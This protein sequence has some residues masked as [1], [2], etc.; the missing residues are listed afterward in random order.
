MGIHL[1]NKDIKF[2][3]LAISLMLIVPFQLQ[4]IKFVLILLFFGSRIFKEHHYKYSKYY[5]SWFLLYIIWS[6]Y[7]I[8]LGYIYNNPGTNAY[9]PTSIIWPLLFFFCFALLRVNDF[10]I[11]HKY[12]IR[13]LFLVTI[14]GLISFFYFNIT[15]DPNGELL[16]F[17]AAIRPG[18]PL[19]SLSGPSVTSCLI[20]YA[21]CFIYSV[22]TI[23]R[24]YIWLL[25][26]GFIF[27]FVTSRRMLYL[28]VILLIFVS[29][30][31]V[32]F[33][34]K[35]K[36]GLRGVNLS[37]LI[38]IV[39]IIM[40]SLVVII[41]YFGVFEFKD[42]FS[43]FEEVSEASDSSR[44]EQSNALI[45]AWKEKPLLGWGAGINA[46]GSIRSEIPGNY[47]LGFHAMIFRTGILGIISYIFLI[48]SLN[49]K[50]FKTVKKSKEYIILGIPLIL[51][52]DLLILS[53]ATNP[54]S[55]AFDF[56]WCIFIPIAFVNA[57]YK[58]KR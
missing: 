22:I 24:K 56:I 4:I 57:V 7:P 12:L 45:N 28:E 17:N 9:V 43:F 47:E 30:Y 50:L 53:D 11:L 23:D 25:L 33:I 18:F 16:G 58:E 46:R 3:A 15:F 39:S 20:L 19:L 31:V 29:I 35:R 8:I 32:K 44:S 5:F 10:K 2:L 54:Y 26:L 55:S 49:L 14:L 36:I 42:L 40:L 51:S 41:T 37:S 48:L 21:Y 52:T 38:V 1:K 27:I 34:R 6:T 13:C